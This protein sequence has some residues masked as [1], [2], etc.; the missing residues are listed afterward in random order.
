MLIDRGEWSMKDRL[1]RRNSEIL[2]V[3][4]F[5]LVE[6]MKSIGFKRTQIRS[7]R[8]NGLSME[9]GVLIDNI[10]GTLFDYAVEGDNVFALVS[11]LFGI[12]A[13]NILKGE[14]PFRTELFIFKMKGK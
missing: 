14:N 11:P 7:L 5:P 1:F 9:E 8:W 10:G 3:K 12:N 13:G 6:M 2:S 4:R